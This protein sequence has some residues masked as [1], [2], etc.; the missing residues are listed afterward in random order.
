M[1]AMDFTNGALSLSRIRET[2]LAHLLDMLGHETVARKKNDTDYW[3]LSPLRN[4]RTASFH[5]DCMTNQWYDFG[6]AAGGNPVDFLLRYYQ[7]SIPEMLERINA[8]F[9]P[10]QLPFFEPVEQV[11]RKASEDKLMVKDVRPLYS[12]PLKN[13]L[14]ERSIPVVVADQFCVEVSYQIKG[15]AYYGI[16]F[17]NDAGGYEIRNKNFKQSSSPKDITILDYGSKSVQ[18]FEGF[19]DFLS[20]QT[21]Q[22][23]AER[24]QQNSVV[25]NGA[26]MFDRALP[27][28]EL[29]AEVGLWLDRDV[30]GRAF[31]EYAM[32]LGKKFR[33]ESGLYSRHKDL[34]D[35]LVNNGEVQKVRQKPFLRLFAG[36]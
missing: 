6:L 2:D 8:S 13:Y 21:L 9:P 36:S 32:S 28:L 1:G 23:D 33:D 17:K 7:C 12:Y 5:V 27:F 16:G 3:Y 35:W 22:P 15:G 25:L 29:Q 20:W 24:Q 14:H 11:G 30:T 26:G 31:T 4:E 18:V 10:H 19:F 34:N